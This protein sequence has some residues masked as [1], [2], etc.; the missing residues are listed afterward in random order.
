MTYSYQ[1]EAGNDMPRRIM[2]GFTQLLLDGEL[3]RWVEL[4]ATEAVFEFPYSPPGFPKKLEGKAAIANHVQDL[5]R[6]IEIQQF[7]EPVILADHAK[8]QFVAEFTCV[9]RSLVTG[10]TYNQTYISVVS[11]QYGKITHY[12]DYWNPM[13]VLE[14][15][16][17]GNGND[18]R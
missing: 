11:H 14:S 16:L 1:V 15:D 18:Q 4:Y 5:L 12:K 6:M 10:K 17:G 7:S 3:D 13:V 9:G 8:Q 2:H